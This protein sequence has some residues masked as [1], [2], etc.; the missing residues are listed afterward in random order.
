MKIEVGPIAPEFSLYS[1]ENEKVSLVDYREKILSY[2]FSR[3]PLPAFV[4]KNYAM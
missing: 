4:P 1:S 2:Y 3:W